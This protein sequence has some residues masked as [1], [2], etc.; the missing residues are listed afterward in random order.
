M[1]KV[2]ARNKKF[3]EGNFTMAS[4]ILL[5]IIEGKFFRFQIDAASYS[6]I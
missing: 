2:L 1:Y 5:S 3:H 6:M 4:K